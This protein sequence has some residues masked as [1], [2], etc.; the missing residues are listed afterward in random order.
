MG[1]I[2]ICWKEAKNMGSFPSCWEGGG[3]AASF[4]RSGRVLGYKIIGLLTYL[5]I[6][7]RLVIAFV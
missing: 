4:C 3:R 7:F 6:V 1:D 5:V 2:F